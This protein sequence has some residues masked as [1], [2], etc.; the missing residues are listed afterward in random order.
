MKEFLIFAAGF[1]IITCL[2]VLMVPGV[3]D[4]KTPKDSSQGEQDQ[5]AVAK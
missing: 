3:I 5:P 1:H 4:L 2:A